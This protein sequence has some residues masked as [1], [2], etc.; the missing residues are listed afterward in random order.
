MIGHRFLVTLDQYDNMNNKHYF[1]KFHFHDSYAYPYISTLTT[2]FMNHSTA[3]LNKS[4]K[5]FDLTKSS[6]GAVRIYDDA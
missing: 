1:N 5:L 2:E 6:A 4:S 3:R